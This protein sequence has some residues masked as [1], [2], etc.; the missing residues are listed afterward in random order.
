MPTTE[1]DP[2]TIGAR[3]WLDLLHAE[4]CWLLAEQGIKALILKGPATARWLYPGGGRQSVDVD[5][6]VDPGRWVD[7]ISTLT[8]HGFVRPAFREGEAAPHSL[9]LNRLDP[10][11]GAH[12]VDLHRAF[13]GI[14]IEPE[15][16]FRILWARRVPETI[17]RVDAAFPDVTTR[18]LIVALHAARTPGNPRTSDDLRHATDALDLPGWT[19]VASL[20][21]DLDALPAL[22]AG[23]ERDKEAAQLVA[24]LGLSDVEVP[25]EWDLRSSDADQTAVRL[26]ELSRLPLYQRPGQVMRWAFPSPAFVRGGD[27]RADRGRWGLAVAYGAR[28]V[29]GA[30]RFP[31]AYRQYRDSRR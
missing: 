28:L 31:H 13:P 7:A 14:G 15:M 24:Q 17:A 8:A 21:A 2:R 10:E 20:A 6:L 23:L 16:A 9:E 27:P 11:Q 30:R 4:A 29:D 3:A 5:L 12:I 1:D 26:D 19:D 18:A 22:R 25:P